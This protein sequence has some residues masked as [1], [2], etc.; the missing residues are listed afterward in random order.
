MEALREQGWA[1]V[2]ALLMAD[3]LWGVAVYV[4]EYR[5]AVRGHG[6]SPFP[7]ILATMYWFPCFIPTRSLIFNLEYAWSGLGVLRVVESLLTTLALMVVSMT[8]AM[9]G[10]QWLARRA[11]GEDPGDF[12]ESFKLWKSTSR[13]SD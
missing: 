4:L 6:P 10:P 11:A 3:V 2:A 9:I 1:L 5:R 13:K 12:W 8:I 7:P